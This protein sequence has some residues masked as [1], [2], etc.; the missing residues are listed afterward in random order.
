MKQ[1]KARAR[2]ASPPDD[3]SISLTPVELRFLIQALR[4]V[5]LTGKPDMLAQ[6]LPIVQGLR[7]KVASSA[8]VLA[9][10]L[11]LPPT[12][13]KPAEAPAPAEEPTAD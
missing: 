7:L 1:S 5:P 10:Q 8:A 2:G 4:D 13:E 6:L 11:P 9:R 3:I 12:Q